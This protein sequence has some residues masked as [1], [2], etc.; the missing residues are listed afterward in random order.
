MKFGQPKFSKINFSIKNPVLKKVKFCRKC[1]FPWQVINCGENFFH[2]YLRLCLGYLRKK[3]K[4]NLGA[5][6]IETF[7]ICVWNQAQISL[8]IVPAW[9][10]VWSSL[11]STILQLEKYFICQIMPQAYFFQAIPGFWIYS[12]ENQKIQF[13]EKKSSLKN[14]ENVAKKYFSWKV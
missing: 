2:H 6:R 11:Y 14:F 7:A 13:S 9:L 10:D 8:S 12:T 3:N 5:A 4:K 1:F